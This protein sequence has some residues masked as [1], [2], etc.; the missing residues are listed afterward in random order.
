MSRRALAHWRTGAAGSVA[1]QRPGAAASP[2]LPG[3]VFLSL[4][5][6][7]LFFLGT[8]LVLVLASIFCLASLF[9][10]GVSLFWRLSGIAEGIACLAGRQETVDPPSCVNLFSPG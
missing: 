6:L 9:F 3:A 4:F 2:R 8:V 10:G 7:L 5:F 1:G